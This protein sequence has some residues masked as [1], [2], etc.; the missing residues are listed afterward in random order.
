MVNLPGRDR[1]RRILKDEILSASNNHASLRAT[2]D[3]GTSG[4]APR[5]SDAAGVENHPQIT[6]LIPRRYSTIA[7]LVMIGVGLTTA[8]AALHDF[9]RPIAAATGLQNTAAIELTANGSLSSWL[10]SVVLLV[11]SASCL[12]TYSIRRHRID[13]YRGRYRVWLGAA[14]AC[15]IVSAN[16]VAGL[17]QVVADVLV[18]V[19][20]WSALR[21][22]AMWWLVLA[23]LPIAWIVVRSMLDM[24]ECRVATALLFAAVA[25]YSV[26]AAAFL[27]LLVIQV[28]RVKSLTIGASLL[29]GNWFILAAAVAY[30]RFIVLDA[31]GL[32]PIRRRP[33]IKRAAKSEPAKAAPAPSTSSTTKS[34]P[35]VLSATGYS[36]STIQAAKTPADSSRWV[37][38]SRPERDR[39]DRDDDADDDDAS[40]DD[41]KLSKSD[42]K[43]L[44]KLKAQGRAA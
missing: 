33:A 6:D 32:V 35:T 8:M 20:G 22:G 23:G 31:Q 2:S 4:G 25:S 19:T 40:G 5:Y 29:L 12:L 17:H 43:K 26:S 1:R 15:F 28:P 36:R 18:H 9:A 44:R 13:D 27:D 7:I 38:G 37:D 41:R 24:R 3:G 42:R 11:A 30:A 39:Y 10:A 14:L 21:D 34:A 16:S